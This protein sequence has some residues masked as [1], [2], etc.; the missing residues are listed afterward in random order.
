MR[1]L[2][3]LGAVLV[4]GA[5]L[6]ALA[7]ETMM[8]C[9]TDGSRERSDSFKLSIDPIHRTAR[10]LSGRTSLMNATMWGEQSVEFKQV[11]QATD[12]SP[13][14][15]S[16]LSVDRFTGSYVINRVYIRPDGTRFSQ[17]EALALRA[18]A[19]TRMGVSAAFVFDP[20]GTER[21]SCAT[22]A[23]MF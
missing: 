5:W 18:E 17:T 2:L 8:I 1:N 9:T 14:I 13:Q 19:F 22:K 12:L 15:E 11:V 7:G 10:Y 21:G 23:P 3:A 16:T 20:P 4:F 6:P